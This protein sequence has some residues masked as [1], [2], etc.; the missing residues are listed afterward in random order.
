MNGRV[1]IRTA[2][3]AVA[4]LGIVG[5][6]STATARADAPASTWRAVI[7]GGFA[8]TTTYDDGSADPEVH[9]AS[10]TRE[11]YRA[12]IIA[13]FAV[14]VDGTVTGSGTGRYTAAAWHVEG[15]S[16]SASSFACDPPVTAPPF[17]VQIT[18]TATASAVVL[19]VRLGASESTPDFQC[20]TDY[21]LFAAQ[22]TYLADSW[23]LVGGNALR[24]A[25]TAP[26]LPALTQD[27][28]ASDVDGSMTATH[29]WNAKVS[30][31]SGSGAPDGPTAPPGGTPP[32]TGPAPGGGPPAG[33]ATPPRS[34]CTIRGTARA[35]NLRGTPRRDVIC[36]LSGDDRIAGLGGNDVII[37]GPGNDVIAGGTGVDGIFGGPGDD[38][39]A[40]Q[41]G[42]RDVI[43]GG[44]GRDRVWIDLLLDRLIG[45]ELLPAAASVRRP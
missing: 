8:R 20:G 31:T 11:T 5:V 9:V 37:G 45:V 43:I 27:E 21:V 29:A 18:G 14:D 40:A 2:I 12:S 30:Q 7:D 10:T 4:V 17:K 23:R 39:I 6:P 33:A 13:T 22:S 25:P 36:G 15:T 35:D 44:P 32:G 3:A 1:A 24:F 19:D 41:D 26:A 38:V 16:G 28:S 42:V 34:P